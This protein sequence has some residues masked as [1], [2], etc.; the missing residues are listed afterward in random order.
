MTGIYPE[1]KRWNQNRALSVS[2]GSSR[3]KRRDLKNTKYA[4]HAILFMQNEPN[5]K[6]TKTNINHYT[7]SIYKQKPPTTQQKNEPKRTQFRSHSAGIHLFMQNKANLPG[8]KMNINLYKTRNYKQNRLAGKSKNKPKQ[9]QFSLP[10]PTT[11]QHQLGYCRK[12]GAGQFKTHMQDNDK[13]GILIVGYCVFQYSVGFFGQGFFYF[14]SGYWYGHS[15]RRPAENIRA[16]LPC[17]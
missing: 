17:Q 14:H 15:Q 12:I 4:K 13:F 11:V 2:A 1:R 7:K 6:N 8:G 9:T 16:F 10:F 3:P 5:F